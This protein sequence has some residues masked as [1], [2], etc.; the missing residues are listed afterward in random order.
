MSIQGQELDYAG[1]GLAR[2]TNWLKR[3]S[4]TTIPPTKYWMFCAS[5]CTLGARA[6]RNA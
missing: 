3:Y 4:V 2:E 6:F 1:G 5:T